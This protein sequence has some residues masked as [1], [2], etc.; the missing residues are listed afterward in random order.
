MVGPKFLRVPLYKAYFL[1]MYTRRLQCLTPGM[2]ML[3]HE[4]I[5]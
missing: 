3:L 2:A 1:I 4:N 5:I